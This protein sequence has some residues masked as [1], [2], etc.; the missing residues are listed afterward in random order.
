MNNNGA[1][2]LRGF[3]S[4]GIY[5]TQES[6]ATTKICSV[7]LYLA[8]FKSASSYDHV[9]MVTGLPGAKGIL[10]HQ[11]NSLNAKYTLPDASR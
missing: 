9:H 5:T 10:W 11:K 7:A 4:D 8:N 3:M 6:S 1:E 2:I